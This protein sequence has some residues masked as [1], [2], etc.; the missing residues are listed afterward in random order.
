MMFAVHAGFAAA[1]LGTLGPPS[2]R[3]ALY[4][5]PGGAGNWS[6]DSWANA[7]PLAN[8][9]TFITAANARGGEVWLR[10]DAGT[11]TLPTSTQTLTRGGTVAAPESPRR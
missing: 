6:G 11:Y 4:I 9:N 7:G 2:S 3:P 1:L 8:L 5:S 10:A